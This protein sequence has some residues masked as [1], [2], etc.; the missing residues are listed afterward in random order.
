MTMMVTKHIQTKDYHSHI[1]ASCLFR[2]KS[3]T[4]ASILYNC[5]VRTVSL[6]DVNC[7]Y[8]ER[9]VSVEV[10]GH[11]IVILC[12]LVLSPQFWTR[13]LLPQPSALYLSKPLF[14]LAQRKESKLPNKGEEKRPNDTNF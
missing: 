10:F 7:S 11:P 4:L 8:L 6:Q 14:P 12:V 9:P 5:P 1:G 2:G 3:K 13:F